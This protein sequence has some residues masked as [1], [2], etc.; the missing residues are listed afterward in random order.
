MS[1]L[2]FKKFVQIIY[3]ITLYDLIKENL[4]SFSIRFISIYSTYVYSL[5]NTLS[6]LSSLFILQELFDVMFAVT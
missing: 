6:S 2:K 5:T 1:S 4:Y 3:V